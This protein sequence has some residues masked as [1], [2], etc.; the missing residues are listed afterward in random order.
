MSAAEV[1][2]GWRKVSEALMVSAVV[3]VL[4]GGRDGLLECPRQDTSF[5]VSPIRD[6]AF[7]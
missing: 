5:V 6:H 2:V 3:V 1:D 7:S 4:D